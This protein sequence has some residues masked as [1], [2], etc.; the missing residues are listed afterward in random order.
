[1]RSPRVL[2]APDKFKGSV[3]GVEAARL[4]ADGVL[5]ADPAA[6]VHTHPIADGG[7]GTLDAMLNTGYRWVPARAR[8]AIGRPIET[9]FAENR[10]HAVIE[11][12]TICG[13]QKAPEPLD[14]LAACSSGV[15]DVILAASEFGCDTITLALG[16][17]A[18]TDGGAGMLRAL[19][20]RLLDDSGEELPFGGGALTELAEVRTAG[21]AP[22]IEG[23]RFVLAGD[24]TNPLLGDNGAAVTYGPQKG[25][26]PG[27]VRQLEM[28][29][30]R[31]AELLDPDVTDRP[32][33][34]AAGGVGYAAQAVLRARYDSGSR[35]VLSATGLS[36]ELNTF[37]VVITGEGSMD[38]Q[39]SYGKAP[40]TL[41]CLAR[42]S[43]TPVLAISGQCS[44]DAA[45]LDE[46]GIRR[47]W[48]L[49]TVEPDLEKCLHRADALLP[50][51]AETAFRWWM[52]E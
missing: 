26:T 42:E 18:S 48:Q 45:Q 6:E 24:V 4:I 17:S 40:G 1:M 46:I 43:G 34:G 19:G 20:V 22:R 33:A 12:A 36:E 28:G 10:G 41:A 13:L 29:L 38:A 49:R 50:E 11:L 9:G 51:L 14:P 31:F 8:D 37:D 15:G 3:T 32:G 5:R 27:Q 47:A 7:D 25:A 35:V 23:R 21:L 44:L 16:G 30:T 39:S 52:S 2:V